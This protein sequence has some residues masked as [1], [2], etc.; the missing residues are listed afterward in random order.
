LKEKQHGNSLGERM[1]NAF[2]NVFEKKYSKAII[3]GTDC[4]ALTEKVIN[5][6]FEKLNNYDVVIGPANDGG[7]YLLGMKKLHQQLF[8]NINWSTETV[9][10]ATINICNNLNLSYCLLPV[11]NDVDEE[12]DLQHLKLLQ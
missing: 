12:K 10:D 4:P 6:A 2:N 3:I 7:Y 8:K 1:N 5:D 11:L 9:F